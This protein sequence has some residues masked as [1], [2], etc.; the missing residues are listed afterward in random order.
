MT[1]ALSEASRALMEAVYHVEVFSVV[2]Q[3]A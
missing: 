3:S 2:T 1:F